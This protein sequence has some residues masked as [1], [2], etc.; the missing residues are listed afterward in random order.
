PAEARLPM[1]ICVMLAFSTYAQT[2]FGLD[3][4]GAMT[5]YRLLP[6]PGWQI[7]VAK[8]VPYLLVSVVMTSPLAPGAGLAAALSALATGH[9]VSVVHHSNQARWRFSSGISFGTSIFQVIVMC[10]AAA[11]VHA[12]PLLLLLC[13]GGYVWSTWWGGH[14]LEQ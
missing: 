2:L 12:F 8:D 11:A 1:T 13:A 7:L 4:N 5:R 3:G 14:V 6:V 9:H 10:L